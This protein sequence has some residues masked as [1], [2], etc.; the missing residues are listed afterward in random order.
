MAKIS[1]HGKTALFNLT[2][3][4]APDGESQAS[5]ARYVVRSDGAVLRAFDFLSLYGDWSRGGLSVWRRLKTETP[6]T[7][8][9]LETLATALKS[10]G[11]DKV[12]TEKYSV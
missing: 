7:R 3:E 10:L 1:A 11:F 8:D 9:R 2:L 5:R 12:I 4:T 6:I